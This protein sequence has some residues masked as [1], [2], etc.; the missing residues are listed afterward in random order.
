MS[1]VTLLLPLMDR[2]QE[3]LE[4]DER[5]WPARYFEVI[6]TLAKLDIAGFD[7]LFRRWTRRRATDTPN[8]RGRGRLSDRFCAPSAPHG[9]SEALPRARPQ[10]QVGAAEGNG[11]APTGGV[12]VG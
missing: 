11:H 6:P 4:R 9:R 3:M 2:L 8:G 7:L 5:R 1:D 10:E 12:R